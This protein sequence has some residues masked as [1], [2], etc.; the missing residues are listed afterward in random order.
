MA[1]PTNPTL[2]ARGQTAEAVLAALDEAARDDLDWRAGR[3]QG[4]VYWPGEEAVAVAAEAMRRWLHSNALLGQAFPSLKRIEADLLAIGSELLHA[5]AAHGIVTSGGSE[6]DMLAVWC[7]L[8][9]ARA[10]GPLR[11]PRIVAPFSAHPAFNKAAWYFGLEVVR[12]PPAEDLT[13][14][15]AAMA[16]AI[17]EDTVLLVGSAP[18]YSHGAVDPI[19]QIGKLALDAA[20]PLHVDAC[21]GGFMLPF[22]ERLGRP[23]PA[24]DFRVPGVTSISADVHKHG[25]GPKGVSLLLTREAGLAAHAGFRFDGWP[26]GDYV[27]STMGGSRSGAA[28]A[29]AWAILRFLGEEGY[30]EIARAAMA[31]T[32]EFTE[33]IRAIPGLR[34]L[35]TPPTNKF[36]FT[37]DDADI[38]AIADGMSD[39]DWLVTRQGVPEAIGMHVQPYHAGAA[40]RYLSDLGEVTD[41]ARSGAL[42]RSGVRASYN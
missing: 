11:R 7:A 31:V 35:G 2:P 41:A 38:M 5:P 15:V 6:S 42:T 33:G 17:D 9:A 8:Q 25:L 26:H 19:E 14:D 40:A 24:W 37:A 22:V 28:L 29:G 23:T 39:R 20:L 34:V 16:D 1:Q 3:H 18:D 27:T 10:R 36:A 13:L 12:I 4:L 30:V 32:D 21:V